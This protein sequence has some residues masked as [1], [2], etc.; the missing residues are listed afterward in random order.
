MSVSLPAIK[1]HSR[2]RWLTGGPVVLYRWLPG[3]GGDRWSVTA[4]T[5]RWSAW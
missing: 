5:V 3:H 1:K 2:G 4:P